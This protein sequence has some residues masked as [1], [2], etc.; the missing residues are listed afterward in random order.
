MNFASMFFSFLFLKLFNFGGGGFVLL[1]CKICKNGDN[2]VLSN[3][4]SKNFH[5]SSH[6]FCDFEI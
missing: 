3:Y 5:D 1:M 2:T 4:F 6:F